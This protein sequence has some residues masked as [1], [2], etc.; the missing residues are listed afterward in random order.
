MH[1]KIISNTTPIIALLGV[2]K[3]SILKDLYGQILVPDTVVDE[4]ERGNNK[5][6]Y[7]DIRQ[8]YWIKIKTISRLEIYN[9]LLDNLDKGE[10]AVITLAQE[11][12]ADLLLIDEKIARHKA[13]QLGFTCVGT[14]GL[15]LKAKEK[16]L[17]PNLKPLI[18]Q[19]RSNGIWL[20]DSLIQQILHQANEN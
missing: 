17:I 5:F 19:M 10:A 1:D 16:G 3:L 15:L 14:L 20:A 9:S 18:A 13:S 8:I 2:G 11:Y 12:N 4:I 6:F 7:E